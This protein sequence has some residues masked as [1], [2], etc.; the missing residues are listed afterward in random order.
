VKLANA[1]TKV[2]KRA[3]EMDRQGRSDGRNELG[4]DVPEYM[5]E[6]G[7]LHVKSRCSGIVVKTGHRVTSA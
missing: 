2:L 4:E 5:A 1:K 7:N 6:Q 3:G